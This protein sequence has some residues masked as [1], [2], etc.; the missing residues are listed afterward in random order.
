MKIAF[1]IGSA[2]ALSAAA[3][4]GAAVA[5]AGTPP[6]VV[7]Q[8][9]KDAVSALSGAGFKPVIATTVGDRSARSACTVTNQVSRT[10]AARANSSGSATN[11][12]LLSLN[13]EADVATAG[14]PGNSAASPQGQHALA[15]S[16]A[17]AA[18][19]SAIA[20]AQLAA[21]QGDAGDHH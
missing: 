4:I 3:L 9:Y 6:N 14:K 17:A 8:S 1:G 12:V 10:V 13:C 2:L 18:T 5:S 20:A 16:A 11:E 19:S 15:S 21:E 7:G